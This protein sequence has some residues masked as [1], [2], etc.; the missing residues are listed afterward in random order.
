MTGKRKPEAKRWF[1]QAYYDLK[2]TRWNIEGG[3]YV[4]ACFLA[5]PSA[6]K[7]LKSILYFTGSS[8]FKND[9]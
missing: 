3:F 5:Q 2:A 4:T 8:K 1:Q 6:E 7:A 9:F